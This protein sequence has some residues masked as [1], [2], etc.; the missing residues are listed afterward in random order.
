MDVQVLAGG[1][2]FFDLSQ[3]NGTH[4]FSFRVTVTDSEGGVA[5]SV[6]KNT[7]TFQNILTNTKP[8]IK[9]FTADKTGIQSGEEVRFDMVATD[10]ENDTLEYQWIFSKENTSTRVTSQNNGQDFKA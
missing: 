5:T 10:A 8:L 6:G 1:D 3:Y 9:Q 4:T 2:A 7:Y